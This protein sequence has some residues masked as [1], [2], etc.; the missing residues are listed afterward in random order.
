MSF[1]TTLSSFIDD[2]EWLDEAFDDILGSK[3]DGEN[4]DETD[5]DEKEL[6]T[7]ARSRSK[8]KS[9]ENEEE[10]PHHHGNIDL[11]LPGVDVEIGS[12]GVNFETN[13]GQQGKK[14]KV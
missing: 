6:K 9:E 5:V 8:S 3:E 7:P 13:I 14:I 10:G 2:P 4:E 11:N 1:I 12:D